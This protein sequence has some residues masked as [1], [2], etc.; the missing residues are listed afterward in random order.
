MSKPSNRQRIIV[1]VL[2]TA[3]V[4]I[5]WHLG[6]SQPIRDRIHKQFGDVTTKIEDT[7]PHNDEPTPN[8]GGLLYVPD[9]DNDEKTPYDHMAAKDKNTPAPRPDYLLVDDDAPTFH[10]HEKRAYAIWF[11]SDGKEDDD[12]E[13]DNYFLAVRILVWQL[14]H[15]KESKTKYDVIIMAS[16]VVS[17][18][19]IARLEKDGVTVRR[20]QDI[21]NAKAPWIKPKEPRW[22][23]IMTKLRVFEMTEYDRVLLLDSDCMV[24]HNLDGVFD[25]PG[26]QEMKTK[27]PESVNY[28]ALPG[29]APLP[30]TYMLAG[31]SEVWDSNH[32]FPPEDHSGLK[33]LG[34]FNAGFF[35][36]KPSKAAFDY[37]VSLLGIKNSFDPIYMEQNL[38]NRAHQWTGPMPWRELSY[39]W[40]VRNPTENDFEKGVVSVHEK[41]WSQPYI[42]NNEKV[43]QWLLTRRYEMKGWY[44][45]IES[46]K[47][48]AA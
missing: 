20:V 36:V 28:R 2:I 10:Q 3:L 12:L 29:E 40:N 31:V 13:A 44:D 38:L 6:S 48:T 46:T 1:V 11:T 7:A 34:Y 45:G 5:A 17:Q 23:D 32:K 41:W 37:Y 19:R 26:A 33:K 27:N 35:M 21:P 15:V 30:E 22:G 43:K 14:L 9:V 16:P 39:T 42:Y 4:F 8:T 18:S 47:A 24:R 25:D